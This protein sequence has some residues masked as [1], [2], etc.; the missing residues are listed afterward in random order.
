MTE[1]KK[2][3]EQATE[4]FEFT[5]NLGG[6]VGKKVLEFIPSTGKYSNG[7]VKELGGLGKQMNVKSLT[8]QGIMLYTFDMLNKQITGKIKWKDVELGNTLDVDEDG[9]PTI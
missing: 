7:I 6:W 1:L 2:H 9:N 3:F 4:P 8:N 5:V